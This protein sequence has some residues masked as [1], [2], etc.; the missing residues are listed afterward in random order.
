[1]DLILSV[2]KK[3]LKKLLYYQQLAIPADFDYSSIPGLSIE[4]KQ[5]LTKHKPETIAQAGLIQ[6]MTPAA[7]SLLIFKVREHMQVFDRKKK[8]Q[9]IGTDESNTTDSDDGSCDD[10]A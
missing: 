1:M 7:I 3:K 6:G 2:K 9:E 10:N 8:K 4:L 5:K